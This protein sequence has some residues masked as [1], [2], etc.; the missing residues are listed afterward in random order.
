MSV[1]YMA[2]LGLDHADITTA[3][4]RLFKA[5]VGSK[6]ALTLGAHSQVAVDALVING[7]GRSH[8]VEL[9]QLSTDDLIS[10][11]VVPLR[12]PWYSL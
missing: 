8:A 6:D 9:V 11:G 12:I 1:D 4:K 2:M 7:L 10:Q 3:Q 5:L